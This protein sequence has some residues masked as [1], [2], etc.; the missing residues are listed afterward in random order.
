MTMETIKTKKTNT[1]KTFNQA[2]LPFQGQKRKFIKDFKEALKEYP[3][4]AVY[5]DLFGGSGLLSHAVKSVYPNARVVWNDF[6]NYAHRLA[7]ISKTNKILADFREI[8]K[9]YP[10]ELRRKERMPSTHIEQILERLRQEKG[11]VDWITIS[12]SILFSAK[13]ITSLDEL[14][15]QNL[16]NN[17]VKSDYNADGYLQGVERMQMDYKALFE[18]FK[19][20]KNVVFLLDPPYLSTDVS[21]YKMDYWRIG[22]YL[23]ILNLLDDKPYFYFTSEKSQI[24]EL[25]QWMSEKGFKKNPFDGATIKIIHTSLNYSAKYNDIMIY[26]R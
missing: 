24:I 6:D 8:L 22:D 4:D 11:F 15:K 23:D 25:A 2:P 17:V 18:Q 21:S 9:D 10:Q 1:M 16:F 3:S 26:K 12:S 20:I 7:N 5:V 14:H 19:N 13:Y